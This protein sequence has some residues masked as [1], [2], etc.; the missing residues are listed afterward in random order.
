MW[1][2]QEVG[3]SFVKDSRNSFCVPFSF[4]WVIHEA[5][6]N[7]IKVTNKET[8]CTAKDANL[9]ADFTAN[10][11]LCRW[12]IML[13]QM[14]S[15]SIS[16]PG[17]SY[18][19]HTGHNSPPDTFQ[20]DFTLRKQKKQQKY[21]TSTC[22]TNMSCFLYSSKMYLAEDQAHRDNTRWSSPLNH[23]LFGFPAWGCQLFSFCDNSLKPCGVIL[24]NPLTC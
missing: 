8:H 23:F 2:G 12:I 11:L 17:S 20:T 22:Y 3:S 10:L 1:E 21:F 16:R 4:L 15:L 7:N 9:W 19:T 13:Q 5:Y 6:Q 18:V 14:D 24:T